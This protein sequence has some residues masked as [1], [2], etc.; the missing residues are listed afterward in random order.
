MQNLYDF[1]TLFFTTIF[2]F[3]IIV[4]V[5]IIYNYDKYNVSIDEECKFK[6][7]GADY[8]LIQLIIFLISC[9]IFS[10]LLYIPTYFK[11]NKLE[12]SQLRNFV[13]CIIFIFY[14]IQCICSF[15]MIDILREHT[16]CF[17][18]YKIYYIPLLVAF[19]SINIIYILQACLVLII[20]V[21]IYL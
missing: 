6:K 14:I 20:W 11:T 16:N 3:S 15:T 13:N 2:I 1:Y 8:N 12:I 9:I 10:Y 17:N 19:I 5:Y 7:Y 18:I 4:G 21:F